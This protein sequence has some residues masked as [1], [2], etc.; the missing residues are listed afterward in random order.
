VIDAAWISGAFDRVIVETDERGK[1][2]A[3]TVFDFKTDRV[4]AGDSLRTLAEVHENQLAI[5]RRAV[6]MLT[7]LAEA[8]VKTELVFTRV[9]KVVEL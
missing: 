3:A 9:Q 8:Q 6:A 2:R 5:Y 7:G 4:A 1:I